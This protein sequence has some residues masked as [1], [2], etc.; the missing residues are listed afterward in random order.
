VSLYKPA[1][2]PARSL[3]TVNV[4]VDELEA[5]RLV[6]HQRLSHEE[7]AGHMGVSRQTVGRVLDGARHKVVDALL[8]GKILA[9]GGGAYHVSP[10][11]RYCRDCGARLTVTDAGRPVLCPTC[12]SPRVQACDSGPDGRGGRRWGGGHACGRGGG[13]V[14]GRAG[15]D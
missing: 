8:G 3:E 10:R 15:G 13:R 9:I 14:Q 5:M 1:G 12:G 7:A 11:T 6:D 2:V 4:T